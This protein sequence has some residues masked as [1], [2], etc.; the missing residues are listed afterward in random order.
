[1]NYEK[2]YVNGEWINSLGND[3]IE[4]EN[5]ANEEII[6][7]VPAST[8]EDVNMAVKSAKE[9]FK[10]WKD[11]SINE[12]INLVENLLNELK[13]I[14]DEMAEVIAKELGCSLRFA[15]NTHVIPY[16][17]DM[18]NYLSIVKDYKF[19]ENHGD[20]IV[21]REPFGVVGALTPWNY[22]LGQILQKLSPALLAGNT[23][24]LKPSKQTPLVAYQLT[25]AIHR[26]GFPK[27][28]FNLTPGRGSE[29]G[30]IL[31]KHKDIDMITFTG[32]TKGGREVSK[33]ALD[34][35]KKITLELGGKSPAVILPG[36]DYNLALKKTL[37][38]IYMNVGQSCSAF[39][40]LLVPRDEKENI[41]QMI[42]KKTKDYV[43]GD[44]SEPGTMIGP[45]SSEKQ[46]KKVSY[47]INKGLEEGAKLLI[48]EVPKRSK[49]YYIGP[50]VFTNVENNMEIAQNEIFGPVLCVIAYDN[51]NEAL[52]IA[53]DTEYGLSSAVFGPEEQALEFAYKIRA[54][55]VIVNNGSSL[56]KAPFG[57]YKHSGIGREGGKHGLEEFLEIK[58]I[59]I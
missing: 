31:A 20:Y 32:S 51:L 41:E 50:T 47:Y 2:I 4:V 38:S 26:A 22:P 33:L 39:S 52:N 40:R 45:L 59:F 15:K 1:M 7:R 56:H 35:I 12:R 19:E 34:G 9:A 43:F 46:F 30:N 18:K 44:P 11:T 8:E 5:P 57:G 10:S 53:N 37:D 58:A 14:E 36:A 49:G 29:V 17:E 42:V 3:M 55:E 25:K 24:V 21:K 28:V 13:E 6:E 16:L 54:G 27:G 23:I 48:G